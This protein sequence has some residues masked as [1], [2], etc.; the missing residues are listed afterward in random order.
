MNQFLYNIYE[1][2]IKIQ[3]NNNLHTYLSC[4]DGIHKQPLDSIFQVVI[5]LAFC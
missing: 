3:K 5:Y 2:I 4:I 1:F